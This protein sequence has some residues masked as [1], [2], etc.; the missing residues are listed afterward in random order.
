MK[1]LA[2]LLLLIAAASPPGFLFHAAGAGA[3]SPTGPRRLFDPAGAEKSVAAA[4]DDRAQAQTAVVR[5]QE[6]RVNFG[7]V[8]DFAGARE[9]SLPL[10]GL[11][12]TAVR[13]ESEGFVA[14]P[15]GGLV[16]RG[17]IYGPGA[18]SGDVTL[19]VKGRALSGL[20]YSPEAVYEIIPQ[21]ESG[22]L[23]VQ[24][25]QSLFPPCGGALPTGA[26]P[27]TAANDAAATSSAS[28]A[29]P[30][31]A[32]AAAAA[33]DG[34]RIDVLVVYTAATR[35]ALGGTTQAEAFAQA[36]TETTNTAYIN[37]DIHT[38][39]RLAGTLEVNYA[40]TNDLPA[41]LGWAISNATINAARNTARADLVAFIVETANGDCGV[42][43]LMSRS[44]LGPG[45]SVSSYSVT[46]RR[47]AVGNLT[48]AHELGHNQGCQHNPE[49]GGPPE[50]S[51]YPYA[52]G[53][54]VDHTFRTVMSYS[55]P[56]TPPNFC[57]RVAH[58]S[59]PSVNFNGV[60][61]GVA[62][63]RDNS[64]VIN[65][66]AAIVAQF[67]ESAV[68]DPPPNDNFANPAPLGGAAGI[69]TGTNN[70]ATKEPGEP[71]YGF[72]RTGGVSVWFTW[73]APSNG[74]TT[75]TTVGS[76]FNTVLTVYTGGGFGG[77]TFVGQNH[78]MDPA[79]GT[80]SVTFNASA[81]TIY[82]ISVD[83]NG[84]AT[85]RLRLNWSQGS[86]CA[87]SIS[88]GSQFFTAAGGTGSVSVAA[89]AGCGWT[90]ASDGGFVQITGGNS[91]A[92]DGAVSY[93]VA[94]NPSPSP[95]SATL[96]A[97]GQTFTVN[98]EGDTSSG[99][100]LSAPAFVVNESE[101]KV[102]ITVTRAGAASLPAS[103]D[104]A[105]ADGTASRRGD[106][107]QTLGAL[108][109]APGET[110]KTVT[111]FITDD[112]YQEGPENFTFTL[113]NPSGATLGAPAS[114]VVTVESDD[115]APTPVPNPVGG[116]GF[117]AEFFVRQHYVDFLNREVD[118]QGLAFWTR[119]ITSCGAD[120][121]CAEARRENVSAAFFL[122]IEFQET[123][124]L[125]YR[126]HKAAFGNLP[127]RPVPITLRS[128]LADQRRLADKVVVGTP[129]WPEQLEANKTAY[130]DEFVRSPAFVAANPLALSAEQYVD[131]LFN[132]AGV[133]P[134]QD[135][136]GLAV[137]LFG[138]GGTPGR[139]AALRSVAESR[140]VKQAETNR[141]FVLMQYF[142]YLRRDPDDTDFRGIPD[143]QFLGY[144][145]WLTKLEQSGGNFVG[146]EMVKAFIQSIEYAERFGQ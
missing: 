50:H 39:L 71:D 72:F 47:C 99:V 136:R 100:Q 141:A 138:G 119:E 10:F 61:T 42:A 7:T 82:R 145:F 94:A 54:Y 15:G 113:S 16:W 60:P 63:E 146:A 12:Y 105:T 9:L 8:G 114:A 5:E 116:A 78:F 92:G 62:D 4:S 115:N 83:G 130:F 104:Y 125:A 126:A 140:G 112:V 40:E 43:K 29:S 17:K 53:H 51:S 18:W 69:F 109:F 108:S 44:G 121:R 20:I 11:S 80:S 102:L 46:S 31:A 84:G 77:L 70:G 122:S 89:L 48:F 103:L 111:I 97:A 28:F 1:R 59:N 124:F 73:Q 24:L 142:G 91:G 134:S 65:N 127:G 87:F 67:R 79:A 144:N 128:F 2:L 13:S 93:A 22:H 21:K 133:A 33:D 23:L 85:G 41:A 30:G 35:A 135:E 68:G 132:R 117:D 96:T 52:Y 139:A 19:S 64:R 34:S 56:C 101:R 98:Q 3:Q 57:P 36:A 81:G 88:P 131:G 110:S 123:G 49:N 129:G 27:E 58:F 86:A 106:Y 32:V 120:A 118:A 107:T 143:P 137:T 90:A 37:S 38:R 14:S 75:V 26:A 74:S 76:T 6:I 66:T 55:D 45:F 95:R 25:D